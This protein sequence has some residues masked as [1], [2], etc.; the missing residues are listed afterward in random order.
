METH[1]GFPGLLLR[2]GR[3]ARGWSQEGLCRGI[4]AV[5]YLSKIETGAAA[6]SEE[7]LALLFRRLGVTWYG[8]EAAR[9]AEALAAQLYEAVTEMD[10]PRCRRLFAELDAHREE[11]L[12]G[13]CLLEFALLELYRSPPAAPALPLEEFA[14]VMT[15]RQ[16]A[17]WLL[18]GPRCEEALPLDPSAFA[19]AV[20]GQSDYLAGRYVQ[21]LERLQRGFSLASG[22]CL[23]H[24][25]LYCQL[26]LGNCYS[27]LHQYEPMLRHYRRAMRLAEVTADTAILADIRYN[28]AATQ[29][30]QGRYEEAYGYFCRLENPNVM[31][32]H[33]LAVCCEKL[34]RPREA[35][36]ALD[37]A[38]A[39]PPAAGIEPALAQRLCGLVRYRLEHPAYLQ[40]AAYGEELLACFRRLRGMQPQ[41]YAAFH[42]PWAEEWYIANRQYK[43]AWALRRDFPAYPRLEEFN[44]NILS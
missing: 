2:R 36:A 32:L 34:G 13:P 19:W 29:I 35:L 42:L 25:M 21:A 7:V 14:A 40:D 37:R 16:R 20:A 4:C 38:A 10:A 11:Y 30:E 18:A 15:P 44:G 8:G 41:G 24:L 39:A 22:D 28:I 5:S 3:L 12:N 26:F 31:A 43:Q 6:P 33:K 17:L 23:V 27:D 1:P 9:R